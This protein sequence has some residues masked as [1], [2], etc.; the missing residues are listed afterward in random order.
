MLENFTYDALNRIKTSQ[1]IG[2][3]TQAFT[4]DV[5]GNIL[6]KTGVGTGSNTYCYPAQG[7]NAI[8]P[9]AVSSIEGLG[10]FTYDNNG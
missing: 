9:H 8:R 1:V 6:T 7:A 10:A 2:Q 5:T 4:F 3:A